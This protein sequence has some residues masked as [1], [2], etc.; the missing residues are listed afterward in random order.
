MS[1]ITS[2]VGNVYLYVHDPDEYHWICLFIGFVM[3]FF[4]TI[5]GLFS[6]FWLNKLLY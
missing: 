2:L 1:M 5:I 4:L 3:A 6:L